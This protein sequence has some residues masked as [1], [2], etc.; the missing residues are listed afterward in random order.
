MLIYLFIIIIIKLFCNSNENDSKFYVFKYCIK[1]SFKR[2]FIFI[3]ILFKYLG[4]FTLI[5]NSFFEKGFLDIY[6][7]KKYTWYLINSLRCIIFIIQLK[8][9]SLVT[10]FLQP[11]FNNTSITMSKSSHHTIK[12][13]R[14][15]INIMISFKKH[16]NIISI[17]SF[18]MISLKKH[19]NII[20]F[21]IN[22]YFLK[23]FWRWRRLVKLD[24]LVL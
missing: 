11:I 12:Y 18:L 3:Q 20:S 13:L 15:L 7:K 1:S 4:R 23:Y 16:F 6:N 17:I 2:I 9:N 19:F 24:V 10:N 8:P 5:K 14:W 22:F 21:L